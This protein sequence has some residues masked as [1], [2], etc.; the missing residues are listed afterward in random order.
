M[1]LRTQLIAGAVLALAVVGGAWWLHHSGYERGR[2]DEQIAA[3][4][5]AAKQ[6]EADVARIND[7]VG[8]LQARIE[9]LQNAKP[10]VI[11]QYRDRIIQAPM[12]AEC[13]PDDIRLRIFKDARRKSNAAR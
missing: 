1:S 3:K 7:S 2:A 4:L 10:K 8:V 9:D 5:A 6:Y 11:T 13:R 12:P